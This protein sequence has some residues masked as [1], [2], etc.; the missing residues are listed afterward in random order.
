ME[1]SVEF[2]EKRIH[3]LE[4]NL[5]RIESLEEVVRNCVRILDHKN[6]MQ[7]QESLKGDFSKICDSVEILKNL[8]DQGYQ[9]IDR[10][11]DRIQSLEQRKIPDE[12]D[13][14]PIERELHEVKVQCS[15]LKKQLSDRDKKILELEM[16][17]QEF[18]TKENVYSIVE[19]NFVSLSSKFKDF[20]NTVDSYLNS[21][22]Q[23]S[24]TKNQDLIQ[25][26]ER[27]SKDLS[28]RF[29]EEIAGIKRLSM[30]LE[31]LVEKTD[32]SLREGYKDLKGQLDVIEK[33]L[34]SNISE[35]EVEEILV[36]GIQ[37]IDERFSAFTS[38]C[39][40]NTGR[41]KSLE[42]RMSDFYLKNQM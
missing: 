18:I 4:K 25:K 11:K 40:I 7:D 1:P 37:Q 39:G 23:I 2:L 9:H 30:D 27:K 8:L 21:F 26:H 41:I 33:H 16:R 22:Q 20:Q 24:E 17:S 32:H 38:Q 15:E 29:S 28:D 14:S 13:L 5:S 31:N 3:S 6:L 42:K 34:R 35:K 19:K 36:K 10:C 12:V